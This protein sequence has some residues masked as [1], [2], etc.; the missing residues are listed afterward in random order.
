MEPKAL[1][2]ALF[3]VG[4]PYAGMDVEWECFAGEGALESGIYKGKIEKISWCQHC[5]VATIEAVSE[6]GARFSIRQAK[7]LW[8]DG[9]PRWVCGL[10]APE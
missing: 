1:A 10:K 8:I 6:F 3:G 9:S 7:T 4:A 5:G 2:E